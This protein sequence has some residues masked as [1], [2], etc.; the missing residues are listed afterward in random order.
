MI[1]KRKTIQQTLVFETVNKL[2]CHA[3]ADEVYSAIVTEH[4][5][6]SRATVYRNLNQLSE[7]GQIRK[8]GVPDGADR[9]DHQCFEHYHAKCVKC[10]NIYDVDMEYITTLQDRIKDTHEFQF[11]GHDIIFYG[12]CSH[13]NQSRPHAGA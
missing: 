2:K 8:V 13:C 11:W 9:F 12:L 5:S 4:P 1:T 3:T 7:S 6:I 10:G